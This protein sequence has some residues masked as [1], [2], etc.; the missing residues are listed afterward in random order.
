MSAEYKTGD[1]VFLDGCN[2][3]TLQPTKKLADKWY[4]P[5]EVVA[6]I[7]ASAY[8]L[9]LLNRWKKVHPIFNEM[10]LKPAV[11]PFFE[12]QKM[13]P[14]PPPEIVDNEEEYKIE[15]ILDS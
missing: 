15:E 8:K 5:F 14:P 12:I 3:K 13:L 1:K 4:G 6:K 10:L 7:G 9:K 2:I 11:E